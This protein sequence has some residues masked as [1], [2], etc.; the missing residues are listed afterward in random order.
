MQNAWFEMVCHISKGGGGG[1]AAELHFY[2]V[3]NVFS[4]LSLRY[5]C[6]H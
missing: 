4:D 3:Q 6:V 5:T 1:V 2:N